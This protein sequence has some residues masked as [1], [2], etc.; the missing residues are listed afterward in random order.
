MVEA[1]V[2]GA[3]SGQSLRGRL[4]KSFGDN[5]AAGATEDSSGNR[6]YAGRVRPA[7][8]PGQWCGRDPG[9]GR[10]LARRTPSHRLQHP[11]C[12][13]PLGP[14][15]SRRISGVDHFF[16]APPSVR[17]SLSRFPAVSLAALGLPLCAF[18]V[19]A[20]R[21]PLW[22]LRWLRCGLRCAFSLCRLCGPRSGGSAGCAAVSAVVFAVPSPRSHYG[23]SAGCAAA[24]V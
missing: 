8:R 5:R 2:V 9:A 4:L 13:H 10:G 11:M 14:G 19:A 12:E 20:V 17:P 23:G 21:S 1:S 3:F 22:R 16:A 15:S 24:R 6:R 7:E 18:A